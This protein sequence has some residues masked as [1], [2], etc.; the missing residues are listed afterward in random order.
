MNA[1][2]LYDLVNKPQ[3]TCQAPISIKFVAACQHLAHSPMGNGA[4]RGQEKMKMHTLNNYIIIMSSNKL[5]YVN[6]SFNSTH[7]LILAI[8]IHKQ[9][10][11]SLKRKPQEWSN[12][13]GVG[14]FYQCWLKIIFLEWV[15][16][17]S[18]ISEYYKY[19]CNCLATPTPPLA[20]LP[21]YLYNP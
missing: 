16:K 14:K 15:S 12:N 9:H 18:L 4:R 8:V 19:P 7:Y 3:S 5:T 10:F 2:Q 21:F 6:K 1:R 11:V 17:I 13:G 20:C